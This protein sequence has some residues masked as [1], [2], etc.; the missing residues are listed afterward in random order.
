MTAEKKLT[1][2]PTNLKEAIDWVLRVSELG[3]TQDLAEALENLLG[4]DADD[5]A[6]RVHDVFDVIKSNI[7]EQFD[8]MNDFPRDHYKGCMRSA[9]TGLKAVERP[10]NMKSVNL[11]TAITALAEGLKKFLGYS[12]STNFSGQGIIASNGKGYTLTY[13]TATWIPDE[14]PKCTAIFLGILPAIFF[15]VTLTYWKCSEKN[16]WHYKT[17]TNESTQSTLTYFLTQMGYSAS[18]LNNGKQASE[19]IGYLKS[20]FTE[21][22]KA[23]VKNVAYSAFLYTLLSK[24]PNTISFPL[25]TIYRIS[26]Y[27]ISYPLYTVQSTSP[28]TPSF[29]S[30]SGVAALGGGAYG[31]NLGGLATFM[32]AL[33]A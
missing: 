10:D 30:F 1:T 13:N 4:E 6:V 31:L 5:V 22:S 27:C 17:L 11:E 18:V 9:T 29:A 15:G 26:H 14:A 7:I 32:S 3:H 33:L 28:A 8:K 25:T 23:N 20:G 19:V 16:G 12:G 2:P 24:T 21:L